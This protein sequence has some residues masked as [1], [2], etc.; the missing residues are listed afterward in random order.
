MLHLVPS[1]FFHFHRQVQR[2]HQQA[3]FQQKHRPIIGE[4]SLDQSDPVTV[5]YKQKVQHPERPSYDFLHIFE[6]LVMDFD[7]GRHERDQLLIRVLQLFLESFKIV[8]WVVSPDIISSSLFC[9]HDLC[10]QI[11]FYKKPKVD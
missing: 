11:D 5:S 8:T 3:H 6:L 1:L 10:T 4:D 7:L 9:Y 2:T